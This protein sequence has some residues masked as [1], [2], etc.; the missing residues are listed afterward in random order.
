VSHFRWGINE[1]KFDLFKSSSRN[2]F[3]ERFS[4]CNNSFFGS[5]NT[6]FNH[7]EIVFDDT[8]VGETSH[9]GNSFISQ[10]SSGSGVVWFSSFGHSVD[11]F[12]D[13]GS[14]MIT[15]LSG[16]SN[17]KSNSSW[18]PSSDTSDSSITS[19]G[20]FLLMFN[21]ES[22]ND[23]SNSFTSGNSE[24]IN[25]LIWVENLVSVNLLFE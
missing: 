6:S 11:F 21:T 20:F 1:F 8:V 19:M 23:T 7:N 14:V 3:E 22:F 9:W 16:S 17:G 18:M 12:V 4:E 13:F 25:H 2:L 5:S 24:N 10:I 15:Q